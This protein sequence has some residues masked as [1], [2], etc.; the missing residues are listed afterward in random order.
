M[1]LAGRRFRGNVLGAST[2]SSTKR[3]DPYDRVMGAVA[4][5]TLTVNEL[6]FAGKERQLRS[7]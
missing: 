4:L 6:V 7:L 5:E 1:L 2:S 3:T